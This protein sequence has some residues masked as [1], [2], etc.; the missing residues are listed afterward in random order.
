MSAVALTS[1]A[2]LGRAE[3][4]RRRIVVTLCCVLAL[5]GGV[6]AATLAA[7]GHFT[8]TLFFAA[9]LLPLVLWRSP[10]SGV[11]MLL[12]AATTIEQFR[13]DISGAPG[14]DAFTDRIPFFTSLNDGVGLS[15]VNI[16]PAEMLLVAVVL[17]WLLTAAA[18]GSLHVPRSRL[19]ASL[20]V[21]LGFVLLGVGTGLS[22]GGDTRFL[23]WELR[24]WLYLCFTYLVASQL[25][26]SAAAI[27]AVLWAFVIGCG[28]KAVQG[29][30]IWW[31][32]RGI[33]PRPE[34]LLAHEEA[35]F[36][37]LF[38]MITLALW[39]RGV[40]L[41]RLRATATWLLPL[42]L[43]ADLGN[44]RRNAWVIIGID[45]VVL[46]LIA[47]VRLRDRRVLVRRIAAGVAV[48]SLVYFPLYWNSGGTIAQPARTLRSL[49]APTDR[50]RQSDA[51]RMLEDAN[52]GRN[53]QQSMPLGNGFG[54]PIAY[55]IPIVDLSSFNPLIRYVPHDGV[56]YVW[57]R[58]GIGGELAFWAVVAAALFAACRI[59]RSAEPEVFLL[60]AIG[61][62][63]VVA[64]VI[65]ADNDLGLFWFRIAFAMGAMLGAVDAA[66]RRLQAAKAAGDLHVEDVA[67]DAA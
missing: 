66:S 7:G 5:A 37:G 38:V 32:A 35:F 67:V 61:A 6:A 49:V 36:F 54:V 11:V 64:W 9:A 16:N 65:Q 1:I 15:G 41:G 47:Y 48:A 53:I 59:S 18:N 25:L 39:L 27:R 28:F 56:L 8:A 2:E 45:F 42:V 62:C 24:P 63:A 58:L 26:D 10:R 40:R 52:L 17:V 20:A 50:D 14:L 44:D 4:V 29:V 31:Q 13:Y 19:A 12:V 43:L 46:M 55:T 57:M 23:L 22:H 51:Y 34:A 33:E 21:L 30:Y 3:K 60:G